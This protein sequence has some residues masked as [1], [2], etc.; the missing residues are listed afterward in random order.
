LNRFAA[1]RQAFERAAT[2]DFV[3]Q[4]A[5]VY[6]ARIHALQ[7][8]ADQAFGW[9]ERAFA[10]GFDDTSLVRNAA[11]LEPLHGDARWGR[12]AARDPE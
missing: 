8:D 7:G 1:A 3:P 2:L 11:D 4:Q 12:F 9:L 5:M 10:A 6:V